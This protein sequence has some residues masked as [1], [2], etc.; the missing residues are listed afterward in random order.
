MVLAGGV[1][2]Q[3][4]QIRNWRSPQVE[5]MNLASIQFAKINTI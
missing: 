5:K 4:A 2:H 1:R 3:L